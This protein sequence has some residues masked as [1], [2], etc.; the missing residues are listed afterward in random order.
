L[1]HVVTESIDIM[2]ERDQKILRFILTADK[3]TLTDWFHSSSAADVEYAAKLLCS[4]LQDL[5]EKLSVYLDQVD[6]VD[7]AAA[8]L[9][10]YRL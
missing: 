5:Q 4:Y 9:R 10:K 1:G 3:D 8:L 7:Q 6:N 2:N